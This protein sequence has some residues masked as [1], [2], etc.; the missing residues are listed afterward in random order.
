MKKSTH[1]LLLAGALGAGLNAS[2]DNATFAPSATE[3]NA[4]HR[5]SVYMADLTNNGKLD[6]IFGGQL[7]PEMDRPGIW[8]WTELQTIMF[9]LGDDQWK[10]DGL[11]AVRNENPE[12]DGDEVR[13]D[14]EGNPVYNYHTE[15]PNHGIRMSSFANYAGI[16]YNNDGLVDLLVNGHDDSDDW[17]SYDG[18]MKIDHLSLYRNNG[19]GTFTLVTDFGYCEPDNNAIGFNISVG[20]YDRDGFVDFAVSAKLGHEDKYGEQYAAA[21]EANKGLTRFTRLYRNMGGTGEFQNMTI[22]ETKG[23]VWTDEIRD[24]E[25]NLVVA[26]EELAGWFLPISG[27]VQL[28]DLNNDGWLDLVSLGY[29][30]RCW[31]PAH[32]DGGYKARFYLSQNGEKFVDATP[33]DVA[34]MTLGDTSINLADFNNDGYLDLF[35][36][37]YNNGWDAYLFTNT[38]EADAPFEAIPAVGDDLGLA[39]DQKRTYVRD[40][41]GDGYADVLYC[42]HWGHI[43]IYY[44]NAM[45]TFEEAHYEDC[46]YGSDAFG[47]V[48]DLNGN[49]LAD[50]VHP[51]Y[52]VPTKIFYNTTDAEVEA[53]AAPANVEA[54]Y[55]DGK[56]TVKWDEVDEA[57]AYNIYVKNA[58]GQ[59]YCVVPA[60]PA[61]GFV[62]VT[63]EKVGAIRPG[64]TEYSLTLP[65]GEYTV[66]V[67]AL[68]L[69][70][71]TYSAFSTASTSGIEAV[72]APEAKAALVVKTDKAGI[73]V[74][75]DGEAVKVYDAVGKLVAA[76]VAGVHINVAAEGVLV[77][78]KG[79]AVAKVVK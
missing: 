64:L 13:V 21:K 60:D 48:G 35:Q 70:N 59:L 17:T 71:E 50:I 6:I 25:D 27:N 18:S 39:K 24:D 19:D 11:K 8:S 5:T 53:P 72:S 28:V 9:N 73:Y 58:A 56:L 57:E 10:I 74:D 30:D 29:T 79:N 16:D 7:D 26:K 36:T 75:G 2:A 62:K 38:Q 14:G 52:G 12:M 45:G 77:V 40:F 33:D 32:P 43:V 49:G 4:T 42:N 23:G 51:G 34:F 61:T 66:G 63:N 46:S 65:E 44:G 54:V 15:L 20:D 68:S 37:G 76:G 47:C 69:L 1:L 31:D 55:A 3:G 41:N 67:Q 78:V 22:A